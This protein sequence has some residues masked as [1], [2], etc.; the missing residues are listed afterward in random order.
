M[1]LDRRK[2]L[3]T[4][5]RKRKEKSEESGAEG[6][7]EELE[8][9]GVEDESEDVVKAKQNP[10]RKS[11]KDGRRTSLMAHHADTTKNGMRQV[12]MKRR[13]EPLS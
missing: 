9:E 2:F 1:N 3:Q 13:R 6:G 12:V 11:P 4:R 10:N 8:V 5:L 7:N